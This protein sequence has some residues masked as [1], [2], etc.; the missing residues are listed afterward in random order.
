MQMLLQLLCRRCNV[1]V[2]TQHTNSTV[3]LTDMGGCENVMTKYAE[4]A[5]LT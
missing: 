5:L 1:C 4:Y 3:L 2:Y